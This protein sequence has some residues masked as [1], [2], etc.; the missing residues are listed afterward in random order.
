MNNTHPGDS[1]F[2]YEILYVSGKRKLDYVI[3]N[4]EKIVVRAPKRL[5]PDQIHEII[6]ENR[7]A[8]IKALKE[9]EITIPEK[10][11]MTPQPQAKPDIAATNSD[12]LI[13]NRPETA[14]SQVKITSADDTPDESPMYTG[15]VTIEDT[16]IPFSVE[17]SSRRRKVTVEIREESKVVVKAPSATKRDQ[18][19]SILYG[20]QD[21]L[22]LNFE[23]VK[24]AGLSGKEHSSVSYK[25]T[26]YPYVVRY[27]TRAVNCTIKIYGDNSIYITA[28]ARMPREEI[29][30]FV[31]SNTSFIHE[32]INAP[33]RKPSRAIEFKNGAKAPLR[34]HSRKNSQKNQ[35]MITG[36]HK[37]YQYFY[38]KTQ[39][40]NFPVISPGMQKH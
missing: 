39:K 31:K 1:A 9:A 29:H 32:T 26:I 20:S 23:I 27:H 33:G 8:I 16:E 10:T 12:E 38:E 19:Y 36:Q 7:E 30:S 14:A 24:K 37:P 18:I 15:S 4:R 21:W 17:Y 2:S 3:I 11:C 35:K 25:G 40:R 34:S 6:T 5:K 22:L 28:P 13:K